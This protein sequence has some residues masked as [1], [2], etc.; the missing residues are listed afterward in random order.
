MN[1]I[2]SASKLFNA[3]REEE[4]SFPVWENCG[5]EFFHND[6]KSAIGA[7]LIHGFGSSPPEM[8][9]L[10]EFLFDKGINVLS[11]RLAGHATTYEDFSKSGKKSWLESVIKAYDI[12]NLVSYKTFII[13]QSLGAGLA[14]ILAPELEPAGIV[15][16]AT[17]LLMRDKRLLFTS[18]RI[19][20]LFVPYVYTKSKSDIEYFIYK[21]R[22]T[23]ALSEMYKVSKS[24]LPV[25]PNLK[26]PLFIAHA[27][28]DE[29]VDPISMDIAYNKVGAEIK[30]LYMM[31]NGG[32]R[33]TLAE[34]P[35]RNVLFSKTIHFMESN[36]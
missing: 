35:D 6:D 29:T 5:S 15:S 23:T 10:R 34:N 26:L 4:K 14:L 1:T 17:P 22:P 16:F 28:N 25:L 33:L 27:E 31:K 21:K 7:L 32:H 24:I 8:K 30:E 20:R 9:D 36:S 12:I 18:F 13:G 19:T 2:E 3:I 11:I